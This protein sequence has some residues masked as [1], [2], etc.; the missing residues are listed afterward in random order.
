[1]KRERYILHIVLD[2]DPYCVSKATKEAAE[3]FNIV[4]HHL[5]PY[6]PNINLIERAWKVVNERIQ[7]NIFFADANTFTSA[8]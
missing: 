7:N 1:M 5:P 8:I 4:L 6:S 3:K 2:Q